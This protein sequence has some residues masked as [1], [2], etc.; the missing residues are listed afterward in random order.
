VKFD[1]EFS[2]LRYA[3]AG[4]VGTSFHYLVLYLLVISTS[5]SLVVASSGGAIVGAG[6]NYLLA[7]G[8]VFSSQ[9]RHVRSLPKF[10]LV[11][12]SG[13]LVNGMVL[14]LGAPVSGAVIGQLLATA[15]VFLWG[16]SLNKRW[17]FCA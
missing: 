4:L 7:Y 3:G 2:L 9:A 10:A 17:S 16:Y 13:W 15:S 8:F 11:T 6:I 12:T 14:A 1:L 5:T